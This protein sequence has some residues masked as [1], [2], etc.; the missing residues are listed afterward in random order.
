M[1][2]T[3]EKFNYQ[4]MTVSNGTLNNEHLV[5]VF[6]AFFMEVIHAKQG[7]P[8]ALKLNP[9]HMSKVEEI[10]NAWAKANEEEKNIYVLELFDVLDELAPDGFYFGAHE[11]S[12]SDFG[13]WRTEESQTYLC[14]VV[15][16]ELET[17]LE[18]RD[19][20][21]QVAQECVIFDVD[22]TL[23]HMTEERHPDP[24]KRPYQWDKVGTDRVDKNIKYLANIIYSSRFHAMN[25]RPETERSECDYSSP[26]VIIVTGRDGICHEETMKW[27][28]SNDIRYDA[29]YQRPIHNNQKDSIIK[30]EI[31]QEFILP[32]FKVIS[33]FDDRNQVVDMWRN[34]LGLTC[35][36]VAEGDF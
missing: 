23:A 12:G 17:Y 14:T 1:E 19:R 22:G 6:T 11:G 4:E 34:E 29:L 2:Y 31:Y 16:D 27:L 21:G 3:F 5:E 26:F 32:N 7:K 13:Y 25:Y 30:K 20:S 18:H 35:C 28:K 8:L 24:K 15:S 33:V 9:Q 36:Q 10:N